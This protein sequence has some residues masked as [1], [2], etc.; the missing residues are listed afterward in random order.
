MKSLLSWF[1]RAIHW[2]LS[3]N[4]LRTVQLAGTVAAAAAPEVGSE[5]SAITSIIGNAEAV[6]E[7]VKQQGGTKLD[8]LQLVLPQVEAIIKDSEVVAGRQIIDEAL[9]A[10]AVQEYA[11]ATVDL[12]KSLSEAKDA[13]S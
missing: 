9:F 8:K 6:G 12:T 13:T 1:G 3:P 2:L 5:I 7:I 10:K 11:Q 4:G